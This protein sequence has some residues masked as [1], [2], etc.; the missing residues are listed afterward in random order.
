MA[1]T[2]FEIKTIYSISSISIFDSLAQTHH[3]DYLSN[4]VH[5]TH[6]TPLSN[7]PSA[8]NHLSHLLNTTQ[9]WIYASINRPDDPIFPLRLRKHG[10]QGFGRGIFAA[11]DVGGWYVCVPARL[12]H[13]RA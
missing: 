1:V 13:G 10:F 11:S 2:S 6:S 7:F 9:E 3:K 8:Y 4:R 5:L 12:L